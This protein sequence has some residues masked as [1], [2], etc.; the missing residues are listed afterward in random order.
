MDGGDSGGGVQGGRAAYGVVGRMPG[1]P[2]GA[3]LGWQGGVQ[4]LVE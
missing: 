1:W 3:S 4:V 2:G